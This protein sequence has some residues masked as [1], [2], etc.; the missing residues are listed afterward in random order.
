MLD[1]EYKGPGAHD[2]GFVAYC[3]FE[4]D[5]FQIFITP[6]VLLFHVENKGRI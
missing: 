5:I 4:A 1:Q 3:S 2:W 6:A